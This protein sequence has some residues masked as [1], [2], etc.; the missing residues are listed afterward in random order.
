MLLAYTYVVFIWV[1][2]AEYFVKICKSLYQTSSLCFI[3]TLKTVIVNIVEERNSK[4]NKNFQVKFS[5]RFLISG[6]VLNV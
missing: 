4:K 1:Y 2:I 6:G 5:L 3:N